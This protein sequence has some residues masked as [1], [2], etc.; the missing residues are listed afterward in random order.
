MF[1]ETMQQLDRILN[2]RKLYNPDKVRVRLDREAYA[3][4]RIKFGKVV[5]E[6]IKSGIT[7]GKITEKGIDAMEIH[8]K[9]PRLNPDIDP[10]NA[11]YQFTM[12]RRDKKMTNNRMKRIVTITI[13][14]S[15]NH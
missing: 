10:T 9:F 15:D 5:D 11:S 13:K 3:R 6:L 14:F 1:E 2:N 8:F 12:E 4:R 7:L